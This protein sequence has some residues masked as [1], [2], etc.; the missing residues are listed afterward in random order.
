MSPR[1]ESPIS[2]GTTR[3]PATCQEHPGLGILAA[4]LCL[5]RRA[6]S[7]RDCCFAT[8]AAATYTTVALLLI[9]PSGSEQGASAGCW[10]CGEGEG[11]VR[12]WWV[13]TAA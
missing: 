3:P 13:A 11:T 9:V 12:D 7:E 5:V 8:S 10:F 2:G 6:N 1:V 4:E